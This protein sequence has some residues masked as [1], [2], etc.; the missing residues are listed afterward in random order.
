[1]VP[2]NRHCE[3]CQ[4]PSIQQCTEYQ[5]RI[6]ALVMEREDEQHYQGIIQDE[7]ERDVSIYE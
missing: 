7:I 1:M 2:M 4:Y 5:Q 3:Y 6:C